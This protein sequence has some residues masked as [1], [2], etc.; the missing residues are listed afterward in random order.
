MPAGTNTHPTTTAAR[1]PRRVLIVDRDED[2]RAMYA[3]FMVFEGWQVDVAADG[4]EALASA[5]ALRPDIVVADT[6]L[7]G[8]SGYELCAR[9]RQDDS[10][11]AI[12]IIVVT[13]DVTQ[14]D[15]DRARTAGAHEVLMKPCLPET[16]A[17][18]AAKLVEE[19]LA[20]RASRDRTQ[21]FGRADRPARFNKASK[22]PLST[23]LA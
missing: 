7:A 21:A 16:L 9:L 19:A 20:Q 1:A 4:G 13:T 17:R 14:A 10:T 5:I 22:P 15:V 8:M 18:E 6:H 11:R 3:E 12:P 2:T 23:D